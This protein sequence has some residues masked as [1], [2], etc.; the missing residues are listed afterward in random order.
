MHRV[1]QC[2]QAGR[3]LELSQIHLGQ[4]AGRS[5]GRRERPGSPACRH[6]GVKSNQHNRLAGQ[7]AGGNGQPGFPAGLLATTSK[8]YCG[9]SN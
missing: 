5:A 2:N 8:L 3:P 4:P 9:Q 1:E 6:S 7:L